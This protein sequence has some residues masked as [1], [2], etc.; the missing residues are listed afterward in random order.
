MMHLYE[1]RYVAYIDILGFSSLVSRADSDAILLERL[2]SALEEVRMYQPLGTLLD[3]VPDNPQ[4]LFQNMIRMST[5]SDSILISTK[6]NPIGLDFITLLSVAICNRLL[7]LGLLTRGAIS[8]GML[9]HTEAIALGAGLIKAHNLENSEAKYPRVLLDKQIVA[10]ADAFRDRVGAPDLCRQDFDGR[11]HLHTL[12][13]AA[14]E[15]TSR[16]SKS[17]PAILNHDYMALV[18]HQIESDFQSTHDPAVKAKID[19]LVKYFNEYADS[20]GLKKIQVDG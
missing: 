14:I 7:F 5:F 2:A 20:F 15:M 4:G 13:P 17:E 1:N 19:W 8:I 9:I 11:W 6:V 18:R 16:T 12:H 10:D 3:S